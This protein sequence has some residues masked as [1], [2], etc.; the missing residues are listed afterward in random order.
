[1][2]K[3]A[4][5][6]IDATSPLAKGA[7]HDATPPLRGAHPNKNANFLSSEANT[8]VKQK[9][10]NPPPRYRIVVCGRLPLTTIR[11]PRTLPKARMYQGTKAVV[12]PHGRKL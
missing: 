4:G 11:K 1:M 7:P 5:A 12:R 6:S 2:P 3:A 9:E 8:L 10:S